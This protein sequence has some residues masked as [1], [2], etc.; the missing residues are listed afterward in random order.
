M[1]DTIQYKGY[2][3]KIIQDEDPINPRSDDYDE[4]ITHLICWMSRD[5]IGD[6]HSYKTPEALLCAVSENTVERYEQAAMN[7]ERLHKSMREFLEELNALNCV[8][9]PIFLYRHSGDTINTTGFG[10]VDPGG[11]DSRMVGVI[12]ITYKEAR[13]VY[14]WKYITKKRREFLVN[15]LQK[16]VEVYDSY[17]R[18]EVFR[19]EVEKDGEEVEGCGG[20]YGCPDETQNGN[21]IIED[22]K[23]TVD[24]DIRYRIKQEGIQTNLLEP[25]P[26]L[27]EA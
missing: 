23:A 18:G 10:G 2:T 17:L 26:E 25:V 27:V 15:M 24:A 8:A 21:G 3:I 11:W 16:D 14:N 19:Y 9:L 1:S 22:A 13:K 5:Q 4:P 7:G 20:Y 12:Y 6:D